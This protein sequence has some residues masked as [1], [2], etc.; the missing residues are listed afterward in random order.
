M[1]N[2]VRQ[3]RL[4]A[5]LTQEKLAEKVGVSTR[6]IISLEKGKY[7]PSITL[8]YHLAKVFQIPIE[9]L[10]CLDENEQKGLL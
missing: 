6:T 10:F 4:E 1:L 8:A 3:K 5:G 7:K 9:K 2:Q